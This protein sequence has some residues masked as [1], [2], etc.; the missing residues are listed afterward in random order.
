MIYQAGLV[1]KCPAKI[2]G[3]ISRS[4][5]AKCSLCIRVDALGESENADVGFECKDYIERRVNYLET[6]GDNVAVA[7]N[8]RP[9]KLDNKEKAPRGYNTANDVS[10]P[11]ISKSF[12]KAEGSL[13]ENGHKRKAGEELEGEETVKVKKVKK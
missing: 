6:A 5:A 12:K 8:K 9:L 10:V 3:K 2:K 1:G 4:L 11:H 13:L 7:G